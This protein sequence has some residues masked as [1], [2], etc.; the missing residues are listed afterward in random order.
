MNAMEVQFVWQHL[1]TKEQ[2]FYQLSEGD[3]EKDVIRREIQLLSN[4]ASDFATRD[5]I[6]AYHVADARKRLEQMQHNDHKG[7]SLILTSHSL[8]MELPA[9]WKDGYSPQMAADQI[10]MNWTRQKELLG[11]LEHSTSMHSGIPP[12]QGSPQEAHV[13]HIRRNAE[14]MKKNV[15]ATERLLREFEEQIHRAEQYAKK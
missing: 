6:F 7:Q 5:A 4:M 15:E 14:A 13:S 3:R 1:V 8:P 11:F 9:D 2:E 12:E 10:R